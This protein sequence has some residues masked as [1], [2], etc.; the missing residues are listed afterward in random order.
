MSI[1]AVSA[2]RFTSLVSV[3]M[4][5]AIQLKSLCCVEALTT[6]KSIVAKTINK[7]VINDATLR[8][9]I[10]RIYIVL[11]LSYLPCMKE[12]DLNQP[13]IFSFDPEFAH[14]ARIEKRGFLAGIKMLFYDSIVLD[15]HFIAAER[16]IFA[17][18]AMWVS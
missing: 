7:L 13:G 16:A 2:E 9:A 4:F 6:I 10:N 5:D 1:L 15:G 18:R 8:V 12:H 11:V 14:V 3:E 17:P